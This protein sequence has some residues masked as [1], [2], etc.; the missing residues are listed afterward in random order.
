MI[1]ST[2]L[3]FP[4]VTLSINDSMKLL[5]NIKRGFKRII[6]WNEYMS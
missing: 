6:S 5:E 2:K 4:V 1:T 3:F